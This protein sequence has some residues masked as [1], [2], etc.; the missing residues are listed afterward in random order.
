MKKDLN[1]C[2]QYFIRI[3]I[4]KKKSYIKKKYKYKNIYTIT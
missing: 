4:R 1:R 2:C 3:D